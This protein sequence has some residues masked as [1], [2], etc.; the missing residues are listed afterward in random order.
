MMAEGSKYW[1][2]MI[3]NDI[4][5]NSLFLMHIMNRSASEGKY[6]ELTRASY[7][8]VTSLPDNQDDYF[9]SLSKNR[10]EQYRR[11]LKML[12]SAGEEF[13]ETHHGDEKTKIDV[14]FDL[15]KK[16]WGQQ[17]DNLQRLI[18]ILASRMQENNGLQIDFLKYNGDYIAGLLHFKYQKSLLMYLMAIDKD[19]NPKISIGNVLVGLCIQEAINKGLSSYDFLKGEEGYKF[20]WS[21]QVNVSNSLYLYQRRII[22][23]IF[24]MNRQLKNTGK[25]I[26][27]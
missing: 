12:K 24:A 10:R 16:K 27:R 25:L 21:T 22:P 26:L 8:P 11:H 13:H 15:Y 1:H 17:G 23:L 20:H 18:H 7:C 3:L 19:F 14:F 2:C 4:P 9:S 5:A 6:V